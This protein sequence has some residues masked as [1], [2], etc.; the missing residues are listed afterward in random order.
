[1]STGRLLFGLHKKFT[2]SPTVSRGPIQRREIDPSHVKETFYL[3]V[4]DKL[5]KKATCL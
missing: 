4:G 3:L 2:S 5:N 1:M